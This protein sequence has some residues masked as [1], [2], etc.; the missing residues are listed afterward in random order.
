MPKYEVVV[1]ITESRYYTVEA[2]DESDAC[3]VARYEPS[4]HFVKVH[5]VD[6][7]VTLVGDDKETK[8]V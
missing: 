1:Q 3:D 4:P 8:D 7:D 2:E 5:E 6:Y